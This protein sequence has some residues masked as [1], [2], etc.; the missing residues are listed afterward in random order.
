MHYPQSRELRQLTVE[1]KIESAQLTCGD[2]PNSGSLGWQICGSVRNEENGREEG[3]LQ[4]RRK[5]HGIGAFDI[6]QRASFTN[7]AHE[8][9]YLGR[10]ETRLRRL[11]EE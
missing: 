11:G 4:K 3:A 1:A 2:S 7:L 6:S 10:G 8:G 5:V 9:I